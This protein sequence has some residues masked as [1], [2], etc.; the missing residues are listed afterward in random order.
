M[1]SWLGHW[2]AAA[3]WWLSVLLLLGFAM[4]ETA[5]PARAVDST[6]RRWAESLFLYVG[7][8][9]VVTLLA[10]GSLAM[11]LFGVRGAHTPMGALR[12]VG[13]DFAV[14]IAGLLLVDLLSYLAHRVQHA[15]FLLWRFHAVH[16]ADAEVDVSTTV[17]HHPVEYLL[18]ATIGSVVMVMIGT[19]LWVLP[20]YALLAAASDTFQHTNIKLPASLDAGLGWVVMTPGLHRVHHSALA[21]YHDTNFGGV[22]T[23]WDRLFGTFRQLPARDGDAL[24]FGLTEM[25][26]SRVSRPGFSWVLPL[27]ICRAEPA[28]NEPSLPQPIED[29][30]DRRVDVDRGQDRLG[31]GEI[32][33]QPL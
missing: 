19:P 6:G 3:Y 23:V 31:P 7:C 14:L 18:N 29:V 30:A 27:L 10:P 5:R 15:V 26:L 12:L 21:L 25:P 8:L 16:H 13:G 20:V 33:V 32:G 24:S 2:C 1:A 4:A 22:L 28:L 9:A 11:K 17:R